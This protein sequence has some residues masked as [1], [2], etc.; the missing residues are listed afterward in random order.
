MSYWVGE[1]AEFEW[2]VEVGEVDTEALTFD[3]NLTKPDGTVVPIE[4]TNPDDGKYGGSYSIDEPG[5]Y[6]WVAVSDDPQAVAYG[7]FDAFAPTPLEQPLTGIAAPWIDAAA[8]TRRPEIRRYDAAHP[9][10]PMPPFILDAAARFASE[11][12]YALSGRQFSG[13]ART[14]CRPV[15]RPEGWDARSWAVAG[16]G[17]WSS[18]GSS[19]STEAGG[20]SGYHLGP[21]YPHEVALNAPVQR[22]EEVKIDGVTIPADEYR[23][24]DYRLLVRTRSAADS[25]P[26]DRAGWPHW[27]ALWL[28][29]TERGTFSVTYWYGTT[30][31]QSGITA[32]EV[33]A[34]ELALDMVG[35][36]NR[37]PARLK[38]LSR[39]GETAVVTDSLEALQKGWTGI[40]ICD[41]FIASINPY[42]LQRRASAWSPDT[43]RVRT[44][45]T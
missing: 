23:V 6:A 16:A 45:T 26:T 1:L 44:P 24:D 22:I 3:V 13:L 40:P 7:V 39:Q 14:Y 42:R 11:I 31:P 33:F 29:D 20:A 32:C 27:Q 4:P 10:D 28:P 35:A 12:L 18:W 5:H 36:D 17:Y 30:P 19:F 2:D 41:Y 43:G 9:D 8:L 37:L 34:A 38:E 21:S 15:A 25:P